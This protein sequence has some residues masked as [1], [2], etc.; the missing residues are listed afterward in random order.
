MANTCKVCGLSFSSERQL[1]GHLKAH[2]LRLAEYY[3]QYYP[4]YDLHTG[5]I[6]KFKNKT[7]YFSSKFNSKTNLRMWLKKQPEQE[8]KKFCE[9]ILQERII[10]K[11]LKYSP[12]QVELRSLM[13]PPVQYYNELFNTY[14]DLCSKLGLKSKYYNAFELIVGEE[15]ADP[16]HKIYID[17][18]EQKSLRFD[19][20]IE[21]KKLNFGDY[22]FSSREASGNCYV[23]RKSLTDFVGTM[24]GGLDRFKKE[25][26]RAKESEA[27]LVILVEAKYN[28]ALHFDQIRRKGTNSRLYSKIR[29]NPEFIFHNVRN[30][31][32]ENEHIQFLFVEGRKEASRIVEKIFTS[33]GGVKKIDLQ[34]FYDLGKL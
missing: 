28:D 22:S 6:I 31:I 18:R 32:Q 11:D 27:Y 9:E 19:R 17:T 16:K 3:Q 34:L 25:I 10:D 4:R 24:S 14:Y 20:P 15:W 33:G 12:C 29:I 21:I 26:Q 1:H 13:F 30:L 5:E 2:K 8:A 7:Q 23:E